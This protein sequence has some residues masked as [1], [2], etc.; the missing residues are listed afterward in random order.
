MVE[1]TIKDE[2][3]QESFIGKVWQRF[4]SQMV[5]IASYRNLLSFV[6]CIC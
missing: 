6:L 3:D 4:G 5:I 2:V 1:I